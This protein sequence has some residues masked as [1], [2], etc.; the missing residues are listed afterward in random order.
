LSFLQSQGERVGVDP[1]RICLWT[2]S[3]GGRLTSVGLQSSRPVAR[4]LV[5][6]YGVLDMSSE[7]AGATSEGDRERLLKQLSPLHA[8]EA[9]AASG[10]KS[11]PLFI[12]RAGRDAPSINAGID[13]FTAAA[14]RLNMPLT[15]MNYAEGDHGFD[16]LNDTPQSRAIIESALRFVR[17][18]TAAR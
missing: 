11:P 12:A 17:E 18:W 3:A 5:S 9:L 10:G 6:F 4:C 14:L 8:L 1:Q 15:V 16:G 7:L 2:F 13:R